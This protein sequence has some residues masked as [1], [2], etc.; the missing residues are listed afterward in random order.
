MRPFS[1]RLGLRQ[2]KSVLQVASM[3]D[4]LRNGLWNVLLLQFWRYISSDYGGGEA[5]RLLLITWTNFY[6][7]PVDTMRRPTEAVARLRSDFFDWPW[8]V[9]Y[10]YL[11]VIA[12]A[13]IELMSRIEFTEACNTVLQRELA[14]Y[15]FVDYE[16][17]PVGTEEELA[18]ITQARTDAGPYRPIQEH[19]RQAA[20]LLADRKNPDVRNSIKE[21]ISAV[22]ATCQ[23]VAGERASLGD[24]L[25]LLDARV[26]LHPALRDALSKLYG[27]TSD[28][29]GIRHALMDVSRLDPDDGRFMLVAC[30]AFV[31]YLLGK[32][33]SKA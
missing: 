28:A 4:E 10:D 29:E 15:R 24:C 18:A 27:W 17:L 5:Q 8:N 26:S 7:E 3:D 12:T 25:R 11:Q 23:V 33:A 2:P 20:S 21:S 32:A 9:V 1:E 30:S 19:L 16:L 14:G 31:S 13:D 6:K 22:E